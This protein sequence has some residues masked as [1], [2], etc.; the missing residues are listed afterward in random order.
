MDI[1]GLSALDRL[2]CFMIVRE[3]QY[4]IRYLQ[5][6]LLQ[7]QSF[8]KQLR[9][10]TSALGDSDRLI[11]EGVWVGGGGGVCGPFTPQWKVL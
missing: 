8:L 10:F 6:S 1:F 4:F 7:S 5:R 9:S 2:F 3:L 11:S